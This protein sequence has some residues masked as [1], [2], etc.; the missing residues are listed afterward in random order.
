LSGRHP[1]S[2]AFGALIDNAA[3][4]AEA[5]HE[6]VPSHE[7]TVERWDRMFAVNVRGS[8]FMLQA[9][10]A[11]HART[12]CRVYYQH[13]L[14]HRLEGARRFPPPRHFE[15]GERERPEVPED[16]VGTALFLATDDSRFITGRTIRVDG[17]AVLS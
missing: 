10:Y 2:D 13:I 4:F 5:R 17:R 9:R 1:N 15:S 3:R 11:A 6:R 14:G 7:L 12:R 8:W 16:L